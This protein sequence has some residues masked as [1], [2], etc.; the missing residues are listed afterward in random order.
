MNKHEL[1]IYQIIR[2]CQ[3]VEFQREIT[4][5]WM[6]NFITYII[7]WSGGPEECWESEEG[8]TNGRASW[9]VLK[10]MTLRAVAYYALWTLSSFDCLLF[11]IAS[12]FLTLD[13]SSFIGQ[14]TDVLASPT[15]FFS[16]HMWKTSWT[17]D[18]ISL[19]QSYRLQHKVHSIYELIW[20]CF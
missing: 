19:L 17:S 18:L 20:H 2:L 15:N 7:I 4:F 1:D 14:W 10:P 6:H 13:S 12:D 9:K 11:M 8:E 5:P 16:C 3:Y